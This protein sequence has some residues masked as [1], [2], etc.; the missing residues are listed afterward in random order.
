MCKLGRW[1]ARQTIKREE[2]SPAPVKPV[3]ERPEV[4][5]L[6]GRRRYW[7]HNMPKYQPCSVCRKGSKRITK[8]LT[9]AKYRCPTHGEFIV[10]RR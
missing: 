2:S 3:K 9:G 4:R 7:E 8:T 6:R 10:V 1:I 5:V